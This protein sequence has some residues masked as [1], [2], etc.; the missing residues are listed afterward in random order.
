MVGADPHG[1]TATLTP[2]EAAEPG[3]AIGE[4]WRIGDR[5]GRY[6]VVEKLGAGGM[7]VVY[8]A[9]DPELDRRVALKLVRSAART[10]AQAD[11][12]V[13]AQAMARLQHPNVVTVYD[14]GM[15]RGRVFV[16]ME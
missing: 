6:R 16:A 10:G 11:L 5:I 2:G 15:D 13:E 7:G 3:D 4:P 14:V 1:T 9:D 12:V 8:L